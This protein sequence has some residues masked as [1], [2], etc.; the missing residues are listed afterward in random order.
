[1]KFLKSNLR[2]PDN[3]YEDPQFFEM[4]LEEILEEILNQEPL[5]T[6][7]QTYP[8]LLNGNQHILINEEEGAWCCTKNGETIY[9]IIKELPTRHSRQKIEFNGQ[10]WEAHWHIEKNRFC[11]LPSCSIVSA[12]QICSGKSPEAFGSALNPMDLFSVNAARNESKSNVPDRNTVISP[13]LLPSVSDHVVGTL[14]GAASG[15][16]ALG[17]NALTGSVIGTSTLDTDTLGNVDGTSALGTG[18][19]GTDSLSS[20]VGIADAHVKRDHGSAIGQSQSILVEHFSA[21]PE[22]IIHTVSTKS[23]HECDRNDIEVLAE[24][25]RVRVLIIM[26]YLVLI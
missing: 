9:P 25:L 5:Y 24:I 6:H 13:A 4:K 7:P 23:G 15:T 26:L 14:G 8:M 11:W 19:L 12:A 20:A 10:Q 2:V 17:T 22:L 3:C 16:T 1:M 21:S 18:T